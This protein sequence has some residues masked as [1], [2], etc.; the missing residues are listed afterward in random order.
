[1]VFAAMHSNYFV[2]AALGC[3]LEDNL[4]YLC[5][6]VSLISAQGKEEK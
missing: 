2:K 3:L 5:H 1:M 4:S 6:C